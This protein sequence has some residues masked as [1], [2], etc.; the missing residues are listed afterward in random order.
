MQCPSCGSIYY[1][2]NGKIQG[3]QRY[4]CYDCGCTYTQSTWKGHP[5]ADKQRAVKNYLKG[6]SS[7]KICK[8]INIPDTTVLY[9]V[10]SLI[11][12]IPEIDQIMGEFDFRLDELNKLRSLKSAIQNSGMTFPLSINQIKMLSNR[13]LD[14]LLLLIRHRPKQRKRPPTAPP[15]RCAKIVN[16]QVIKGS[17]LFQNN[18]VVK[19]GKRKVKCHL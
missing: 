5:L 14:A 11:K 19:I 16:L 9:W 18:A 7:R 15:E 10:R 3:K 6:L 13:H 17:S 2:K 1:V 12:N 4:K 8:K